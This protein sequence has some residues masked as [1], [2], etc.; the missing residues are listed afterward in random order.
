M[1]PVASPVGDSARASGFSDLG[2]D[3]FLQLLITQITHQDPL[4]PMGN[5]ELLEQLASV[6][7][8]ELSTTLTES[9]RQLTGQD[10][11]SSAPSLIGKYITSVPGSDGLSRQGV[12]VGVRFADAGKPML[13]LSDGSE[14]PV[15]QV[16]T[17]EPP[18]RA[19]E[20]LVGQTIVGVD[21]RD[22]GKP[23]M[24]EGLVTSVRADGSGEVVLELDS[25]Q[26]LRFRDVMGVT[27]S[28]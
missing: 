23:E 13:Q 9:L 8:I 16:L 22:P 4:E 10:R 1:I 17:I 18:L 11:F 24:V 20:A 14:V 26:Q 27:T 5:T 21:R 3:D 25:G 15:E 2:S 28:E 7:E 6:R 19:A 12:V